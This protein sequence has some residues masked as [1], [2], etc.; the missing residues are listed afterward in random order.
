M[1]NYYKNLEKQVQFHKILILYSPL[2]YIISHQTLRTSTI[3]Y[4]L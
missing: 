1:N 3:F 4:L 2:S